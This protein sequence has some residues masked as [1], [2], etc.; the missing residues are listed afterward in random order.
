VIAEGDE[1]VDLTIKELSDAKDSDLLLPPQIQTQSCQL[2]IRCVKAEGLPKM[3]DYGG[4]CDA[5]VKADFSG[6]H[7]KTTHVEADKGT[8]SAYWSED[9]LMPVTIPC[10]TGRLFVR[11]YDW[12]AA[13]EDDIIGTV[14]F[15]FTDIEAGRYKDYFWANI[16]GAP[17][18]KSGKHTDK[19][20]AEPRYASYWRGRVLLQ[21]TTEPA[22]KPKT[23]MLK[24]GLRPETSG[25]SDAKCS[26]ELLFR[27]PKAAIRYR[28]AGV[29]QKW[30]RNRKNATLDGVTGM[31]R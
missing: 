6:C 7:L 13:S 4:T 2:K 12:D 23:K 17:L 11:V 14:T 30:R 3:D 10:V 1:Q 9:L 22:K 26:L 21:I 19:M 15:S 29:T 31:R 16:Y 5:Y 25:K 28:F 24:I 18:G 27:T 8:F 20:N